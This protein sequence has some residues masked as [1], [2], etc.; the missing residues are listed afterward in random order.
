M[1]GSSSLRSFTTLSGRLTVDVLRSVRALA[2]RRRIRRIMMAR[3]RKVALME[4]IAVPAM[5]PWDSLLGGLAARAYLYV[6]S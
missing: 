4:P 2:W 1:P 6:K 5:A 3:N